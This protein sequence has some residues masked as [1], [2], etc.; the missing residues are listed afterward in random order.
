VNRL[1]LAALALAPIAAAQAPYRRILGAEKDPGQWLTYSGNYHGHRFSPLDQITSRNAA[2]LR[3]V[4][5][6][7]IDRRDKF[8][9]TPLVIDGVM[10]ISEPPSNVTALDAR[11]GRPIWSYRRGIPDGL[12]VCCGTVNRGVAALDDLIFVGTI[13]AHLV[14]LDAKT[15]NVVWDVEVANA[16]AGISITAAPL[17]FKDKVV[18]G[19]AGGEFGVRGF[20]DAYDA[21][22]GKR[23]WRFWTVPAAGEPGVETW[24]GESWKN[25]SATTWV[26]GSYDPESNTVFWGTG[27]PGPDWHGDKRNGDNLYSDCLLALDGD[28]G[29]KK[30][31]FQFTPHDVHDWDSTQIPVLVD[32]SLRGQPRRL[33]LFANRNAFFYALDRATGEFLL[34]KTFARQTWAKGLDDHGRPIRLPNTSPTE[35]GTL[36]YP[37]VPGATNYFSPSYS[38]RTGLFYVA[39]RD[40][41]AVYFTRDQK[42]EEGKWFLGGRFIFKPNEERTGAVRALDP[43]TGSLKWEYKLHS[44]PWAGLLSTAGGVVFGG[45]DEGHFYALDD[46]TGRLLWRFPTGGKILSSPVS[47]LVD[48]RQQ[49]AIAAGHDIVV[50][51]LESSQR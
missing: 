23:A 39:A 31:H 30:W 46:Q 1:L 47:F 26:T 9:T 3:P 19:I 51:G 28:T 15:G 8:E 6:Y 43:E 37:S 27:N 49:V 41:G 7:Q 18:V 12:P 34:G 32:R 40:E 16:R 11:T 33:V 22:T 45:S 4:W 42:F 17:A 20:L 44:P 13:D 25:G 50:F 29:K 35:K 21:R 48:G 38:P 14:A 2:G 36:V 5:L 10:Y 24:A